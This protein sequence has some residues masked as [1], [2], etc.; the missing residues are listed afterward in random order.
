MRGI[1]ALLGIEVWWGRL[2]SAL[3]REIGEMDKMRTPDVYIGR[4]VVFL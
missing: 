2:E 3:S 1:V 4:S